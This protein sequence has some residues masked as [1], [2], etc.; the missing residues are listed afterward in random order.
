VLK[1]YDPEKHQ[2]EEGEKQAAAKKGA[3]VSA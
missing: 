3:R 2:A 1:T